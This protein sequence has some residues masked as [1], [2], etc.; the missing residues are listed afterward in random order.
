MVYGLKLRSNIISYL[1]TRWSLE[2]LKCLP[3][4]SSSHSAPEHKVLELNNTHQMNKVHFPAYLWAASFSSLAVCGVLQTSQWHHPT[5]TMRYL[6]LFVLDSLPPT[7]PGCSL[8]S[9]VQALWGLCDKAL[10][11]SIRLWI[12]VH[13]PIWQWVL[14]FL[15]A[16]PSL[17]SFILR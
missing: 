17:C 11:F 5:A 3:T 6:I 10:S 8:Q 4:S 7:A 1:D 14:A 13:L 2:G 12:H 15:W 9:W 16:S